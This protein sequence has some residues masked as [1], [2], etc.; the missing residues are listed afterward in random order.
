MTSTNRPANRESGQVSIITVIVFILLFSVLVIS[1]SRIVVTVSRQVMNDELAAS[2][3]AAAESGIEDAK[4]ILSYC[5]TNAGSLDCTFL[6]KPVTDSTCMTIIGNHHTLLSKLALTAGPDGSVPVG[7]DNQSYLCLKISTMTKDLLGS[8]GSDG[9]TPT[10]Q[11]LPLKTVDSSG[12]PMS[13]Q[14]V[15]IQ[16][17]SSVAGSGI[18]LLAGSDLPTAS[19]WGASTPAVLRVEFV[20]VPR[21]TTDPDT[22]AEVD[23]GFTVSDLTNNTRAVTLRPTSSG[24]SSD[25]KVLSDTA[26][27]LDNWQPSTAP[28]DTATTKTFLIKVQCSTTTDYAC[29]ATFAIP[30]T[31]GAEDATDYLFDIDQY[32][33][34]VRLQAI[35]HGT[36]FRLTAKDKDGNNLYFSGVQ[37]QV[38]VTGRATDSLKRLVTRLNPSNGNAGSQWWPD[39]AIDSAGKVCKI[40]SVTDDSGVDNCSE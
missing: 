8:L 23:A 16:W 19:N 2:A 29:S 40:M 32:D 39:Y 14:T 7:G 31:P 28:A 38:D 22:G 5:A 33:Y 26:Y 3:K 21:K 18:N 1:F 15:T 10:S 11:V 37:A 6:Q 25:G 36:D 9:V 27:N 30:Q 17:H 12:N 35:Y 24:S 4:R 20:A 34:Y 13:P